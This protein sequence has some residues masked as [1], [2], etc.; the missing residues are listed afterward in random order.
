MLITPSS[1]FVA[2]TVA[3]AAGALLIASGA[4]H[5]QSPTA[6]PPATVTVSAS[7]TATV[8]NDRLQAWL[9]AEGENANPAAAASQVNTVIAKALVIAKAYPAIKV[10]SAGYSTQQISDKPKPTRWRVVQ[11][12]IIDS[13]DFTA[14]ASLISRFQEEEGLLLSGMGFSLSDKTRK[15]AEDSVTLQA[16]KSWQARAHQAALGLGFSG[17]APGRISVQTGDAGRAQ[18]MMRAQAMATSPGFAPVAIEA[19]TTEV[20]VTVSGEAILSPVTMPMR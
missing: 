20:S 8:Q 6:A 9:R 3:G 12:L 7:S 15:D 19:G 4:L 18:P 14:A 10:A 1:S 17:W 2:R 13:G 5:A 16:I 11:S